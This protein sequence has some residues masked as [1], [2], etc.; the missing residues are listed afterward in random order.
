MVLV[1]NDRGQI[2]AFRVTPLARAARA[3]RKTVPETPAP[4]PEERK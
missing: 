1:I 4:T 3:G 2:S